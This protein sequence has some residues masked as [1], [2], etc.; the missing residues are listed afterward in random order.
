[1]DA[2]ESEEDG[3][4]LRSLLLSKNSLL[5]KLKNSNR[6][7]RAIEAHL[8]HIKIDKWNIAKRSKYDVILAHTHCLK[9]EVMSR[10]SLFT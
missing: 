8:A 6:D 10:L 7:T 1:M 2:R 4:D 5:S 9:K 3:E